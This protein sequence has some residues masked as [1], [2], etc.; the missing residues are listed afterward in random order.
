MYILFDVKT[1]MY[2]VQTCMYIVIQLYMHF[3][4]YKHVHIMYI[5]CTYMSVAFFLFTSMYVKVCTDD[6]MCTGG[7]KQFNKY[8]YTVE[9][10][11]YTDV[12]F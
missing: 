6:V 11:T 8:T 10:C 2:I 7:Y 5:L 1:C 3:N 12:S 9:H 4:S